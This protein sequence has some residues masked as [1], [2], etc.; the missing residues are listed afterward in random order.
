[1]SSNYHSILER[2]F[3]VNRD[4]LIDN[5]KDLLDE[6]QVLFPDHKEFEL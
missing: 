1:M 3:Q 4:Y 5:M 6:E 2:H